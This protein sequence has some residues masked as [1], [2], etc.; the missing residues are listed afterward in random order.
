MLY[1]KLNIFAHIICPLIKKVYSVNIKTGDEEISVLQK[2][3]TNGNWYLLP[4]VYYPSLS[5]N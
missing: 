4:F 3:F 1:G 2:C 5:S